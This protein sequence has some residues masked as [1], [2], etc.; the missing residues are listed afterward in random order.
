[1]LYVVCYCSCFCCYS[2]SC[3]FYYCCRLSSI[4]CCLLCGANEAK[5][6]RLWMCCKTTGAGCGNDL[7]ICNTKAHCEQCVCASECECVW[8]SVFHLFLRLTCQ[9]F[10]DYFKRNTEFQLHKPR[11]KP[12]KW[13]CQRPLNTHTQRKKQTEREAPFGRVCHLLWN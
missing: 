8:V 13:A 11:V 2:Y 10:Q 6:C 5:A 12:N 7:Q 1:M 3:C 4:K 9:R